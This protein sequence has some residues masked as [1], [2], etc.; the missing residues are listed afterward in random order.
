MPE[1]LKTE[2]GVAFIWTDLSDEELAA[3][4]DEITTKTVADD[5]VTDR[6]TNA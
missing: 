4:W 5:A 6:R 2:P 1:G 3:W